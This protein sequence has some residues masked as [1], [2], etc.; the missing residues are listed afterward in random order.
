MQ[1]NHIL[2]ACLIITLV[3]ALN[4]CTKSNQYEPT[5]QFQF[6]NGGA[7][8][9]ITTDVTVNPKDSISFQYNATA[10]SDISKIILK[11]GALITDTVIVPSASKNA[12]TGTKQTVADSVPGV[13]A[14]SFSAYDAAGNILGTQS[15]VVT[16]TADFMYYTN[17]VLYVPDTTAKTNQTYFSTATGNTYSYSGGSG[18]AASI[19]F[20]FFNDTTTALK[21]TIYA[22]TANPV[23]FYDLSTWSNNATIFKLVKSVS[24]VSLNSSG[25]LRTAGLAN[26]ASGTTSK[27]T[28]LVQG[29]VVLF[30][31]AGGKYGAISVTFINSSLP[32]STSYMVFDVKIQK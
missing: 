26:L 2:L 18:N 5:A 3:G 32:A 20:G 24:M 21:S 15:L 27:I 7:K 12:F 22:L 14:Y 30:K 17:R 29:N 19:D 9:Y 11:K 25:A 28:A 10:T 31:T 13:Y 4:S 23:S 1:R 8:Y 6:G 16:V